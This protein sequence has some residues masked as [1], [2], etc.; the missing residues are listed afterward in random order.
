[1]RKSRFTD[2]QILE[3]L[4]EGEA[5]AIINKELCRKHGISEATYYR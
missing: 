3:T 1:M 5:G 4:A 2:R